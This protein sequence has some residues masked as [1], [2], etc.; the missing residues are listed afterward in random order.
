MKRQ[1]IS[2]MD[3]FPHL[4]DFGL[5]WFDVGHHPDSKEFKE[6]R[7]RL[8]A[9][10]REFALCCEFLNE[11][12]QIKTP[13]SDVGSSYALKHLVERFYDQ[14]IPHGAFIAAVIHLGIAHRAIWDSTAVFVGL[15]SKCPM[16]T[17]LRED[18]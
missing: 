4:T 11:C 15:S 10:V 6:G 9:S 2:V 17:M 14:Y 5:E 12:K 8:A 18:P 1:L 16:A 13:N 7:K 3:K